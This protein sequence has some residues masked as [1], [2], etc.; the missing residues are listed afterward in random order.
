M[1]VNVFELFAKLMM[2][3][4]EFEEGL[5]RSRRQAEKF[6]ENIKKVMSTVGKVTLAGLG[7]AATGV[8]AMI[9]RSTSSYGEY[10]QLVGGVETLFKGDG[11]DDIMGNFY[12]IPEP[13]SLE[14]I[15]TKLGMN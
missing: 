14:K 9:K 10:E 12:Y 3:G 11:D 1:A 5:E 8:G 4:S 7:A 6:S 2:D 13:G 15:L